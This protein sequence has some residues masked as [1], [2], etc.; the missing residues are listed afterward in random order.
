ML[1]IDADFDDATHNTHT[2]RKGLWR[3]AEQIL[4]P[5]NFQLLIADSHA[6]GQLPRNDLTYIDGDHTFEGCLADLRLAAPSA[7]AILVDDYDSIPTVR[8]ACDRFSS[9]SPSFRTRYIDNRL[10]GMVLFTR[11]ETST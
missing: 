11:Q 5:F 2:G 6:I 4:S 9:D 3:H 7:A 1:G 10:T 8:E